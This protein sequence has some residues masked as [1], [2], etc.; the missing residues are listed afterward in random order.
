MIKFDWSF[1]LQIRYAETVI[2]N[3]RI[4]IGVMHQQ[5]RAKQ[6]H[7]EIDSQ[8]PGRHHR[9]PRC[10]ISMM[11]VDVSNASSLKAQRVIRSQP[12]V[13]YGAKPPERRFSS[14]NQ[15]T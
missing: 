14:A 1:Y 7:A 8:Q 4:E 13:E 2:L 5:I 3:L 15:H 10:K 9:H 6:R 12:S 11:N